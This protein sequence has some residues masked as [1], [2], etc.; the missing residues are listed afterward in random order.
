MCAVV[1]VGALPMGLI[2]LQPDFGT[3]LVFVA[4]I[5]LAMIGLMVSV[6]RASQ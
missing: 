1:V 2:L 6:H 4:L 3:F 5:Q